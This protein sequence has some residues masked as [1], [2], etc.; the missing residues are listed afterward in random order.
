MLYTFQNPGEID[1]R[2][3]YIAGLSAKVGDSPIGQFGTGL[4]YAIACVLRWDGEFVIYSGTEHF[5]FTK[6]TIDFRGKDHDEV[7]INGSPCGF[8]TH[9]GHQWEPWQAWRELASNARDEGGEVFSGHKA[10]K[11][12]ITTIQVKCEKFRESYAERNTILLPTAKQFPFSAGGCDIANEVSSFIYY[13]GVRVHKASTALLYNF[14]DGLKLTEDRTLANAFYIPYRMASAIAAL[15]DESLIFKALVAGRTMLESE[16]SFATYPRPT[17]EFLNVAERLFRANQIQHD[18]L[19][20]VLTQHRPAATTAQAITLSPLRQRMLD[21]AIALVSTMGMHPENFKII[22]AD[23][24]G[25]VLGKALRDTGTVILSPLVFDQGAKQVLSTL[26]E[27]LVHL[28]LNKEDCTYDMQTFLFNK[29]VSMFEE[30]QL[31]EP[32]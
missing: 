9:Y 29:W 21:R 3:A 20:D 17:E 22:V 24:G 32:I 31:G 13:R 30:Y 23:L 10:P 2:G 18:R 11:L 28:E 5:E 6:R 25:T 27:E 7:L 15:T 12:G 8:T 1:I 26:L 4:K 14:K 16:M 19:R